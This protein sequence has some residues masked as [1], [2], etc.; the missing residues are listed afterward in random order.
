MNFKIS[1]EFLGHASLVFIRFAQMWVNYTPKNFNDYGA[2]RNPKNFQEI[3]FW[4]YLM[5]ALEKI[6]S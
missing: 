6:K 3:I 2:P 4:I 5:I 1:K